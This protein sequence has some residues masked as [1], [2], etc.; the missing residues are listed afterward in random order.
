MMKP[1][2][3]HTREEIFSQPHAWAQTLDE[4]NRKCDEVKKLLSA[5]SY[6]YVVLTG[7]GSSYYLSLAAA[8]V[9]QE[10]SGL[11]ARGL[12]ASEIWLDPTLYI[13]DQE[14]LL[15]A[16]SRSGQTTETVQACKT[17]LANGYGDVLTISC[18][19]GKALSKVGSHHLVFPSGQ[20]ES[21]AQT[22]SFTSQFLAAVAL[23]SIWWNKKECLH[24]LSSLPEACHLLLSKYDDLIQEC[25]GNDKVD[26]FYFLGSGLRFGLASE[27][28]LKMKEMS[29][30]LS[31]AYPFLEFRHGPMSMV[32]PG[33][34][35]VGLLS[36]KNMARELE[37]L[38][39]MHHL[40][41]QIMAITPIELAENSIDFAVTLPGIFSDVERGVLYLPLL[42]LLAFYRALHHDQDPDCP[43][44]LSSVVTLKDI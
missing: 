21:V 39:E 41:A 38:E 6:K 1:P 7:C 5:N 27:A 23:S 35:V 16:V 44:H 3:Y 33:S 18:Y 19:P 28:M 31:E 37:V 25:A 12:P 2:G 40:G 8:R 30:S 26:R 20:E 11:L 15:I 9:F 43:R 42:Q 17:F 14:N 4:L 13:M 29:L 22:R 34:L 24:K 10:Q 36:E 32:S